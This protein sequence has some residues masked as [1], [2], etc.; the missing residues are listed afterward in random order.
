M[1][2][3]LPVAQCT[4]IYYII[5]VFVK[6]VFIFCILFHQF[7]I[8]AV[9]QCPPFENLYTFYCVSDLSNRFSIG[10]VVIVSV[11]I[12][13]LNL[14]APFCFALL[15]LFVWQPECS[16]AFSCIFDLLFFFFLL[17]VSSVQ[18]S[19]LGSLTFHVCNHAVCHIVCRLL[20]ERF[21]RESSTISISFDFFFF[22]LIFLIFFL[23]LTT[24]RFYALFARPFNAD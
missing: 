10:I 21:T 7:R 22:F 18:M 3:A 17:F 11:P 4:Y 5:Y 20:F 12:L 9:C 8:S 15:C 13:V 16:C 6:I 1:V 19:H 2:V 23:I 14:M 24:L